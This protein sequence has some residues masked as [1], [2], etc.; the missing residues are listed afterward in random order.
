MSKTIKTILA[1]L[2]ELNEDRK[3]FEAES[4]QMKREVGVKDLEAEMMELIEIYPFARHIEEFMNGPTTAISEACREIA[5]MTKAMPQSLQLHCL[6]LT[7]AKMQ[8]CCLAFDKL[9]AAVIENKDANFE[10]HSEKV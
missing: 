10:E 1:A 8:Y 6:K 4:N 3:E 7:K 5:T 9:M 2:E